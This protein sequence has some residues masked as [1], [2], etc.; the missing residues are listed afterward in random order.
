MYEL[1]KVDQGHGV[2]FSQLHIRWQMSQST[3]VSVT[4]SYHLREIITLT[5]DLEI[6]GQGNG[7]ENHL[8]LRSKMFEYVLLIFFS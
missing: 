2:Q 7:G 8:L 5:F 1:Q 3:N 4:G 6:V